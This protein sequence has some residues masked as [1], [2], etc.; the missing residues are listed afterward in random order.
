MV[1]VVGLRTRGSDSPEPGQDIRGENGDAS[2]RSNAG[3][4]LL[5][6][7][8]AVSELIADKNNS[9]EAGDFGDRPCEQGL[10]GGKACVKGSAAHL[11]VRGGRHQQKKQEDRLRV[12]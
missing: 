4:S 10:H 11:R 9:N 8:I 7:G 1:E 2:A 3:E 6:A 5:R 12:G